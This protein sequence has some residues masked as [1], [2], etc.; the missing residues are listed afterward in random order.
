MTVVAL[1][2]NYLDV[3]VSDSDE[4]E[5]LFPSCVHFAVHIRMS[6]FHVLFAISSRRE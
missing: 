6:L 5:I 3:L 2:P 1:Y 4:E